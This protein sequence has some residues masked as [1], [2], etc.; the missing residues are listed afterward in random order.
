MGFRGSG[1]THEISAAMM[2]IHCRAVSSP[3]RRVEEGS[4]GRAAN[5]HATPRGPEQGRPDA[6][7][8]GAFLDGDGEVV[9][10]PHRELRKGRPRR[11]DQAGRAIAQGG[12]VR[13]RSLGVGI[14]R[15]DGHEP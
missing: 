11:S 7:F 4:G 15:R 13:A 2:T 3:E 9:A 14:E 5:V 6:Y 10:H 8:R 1:L 12:E